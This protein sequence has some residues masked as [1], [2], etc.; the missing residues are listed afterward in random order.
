MINHITDALIE[1]SNSLKPV[2]NVT[3]QCVVSSCLIKS[4]PD[5]ASETVSELLFGESLELVLRSNDWA[6]I[7]SG[8]D[9]YVGWVPITAIAD[10]QDASTHIVS[11]PLTHLYER[12]DLKSR[13]L[14]QLSMGSELSIDVTTA[15]NR[16]LKTSTGWVFNEHLSLITDA[17]PDPVAIAERLI[18]TPYL[19]GGR[20]YTGLDCS[21][22]IQIPLKIC[23]HRVPRDS[24]MQFKALGRALAEDEKPQYGDIAFFPGHVGWMMDGEHVLHANATHMAVTIDPLSYVIKWVVAETDKDPFLGFRRL[25][26]EQ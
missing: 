16:F 21:A 11:T 8:F 23:C 7:I 18:G 13:P 15:E 2:S 10:I 14:I 12:P 5:T 24:S 25:N 9:N 19:W 22:L 26:L 3:Y 6:Q 17:A 20:S 4:A 1:A